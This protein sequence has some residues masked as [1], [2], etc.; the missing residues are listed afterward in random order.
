MREKTGWGRGE[1]ESVTNSQVAENWAVDISVT[2]TK[3]T[4]MQRERTVP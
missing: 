2:K 3:E 1:K 4:R